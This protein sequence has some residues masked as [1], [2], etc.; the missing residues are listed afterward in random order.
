LLATQLFE[1]H[2]LAPKIKLELSDDEAV[3]EAILAGLGVAIMS[4]YTLGLESEV[5]RL[6]CLDVEGFPLENH[7]HLAY[8]VGKQLSAISRAFMDFA[9]IEAKALVQDSIAPGRQ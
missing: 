6:I 2:G 1:R 9:R 3:K 7:W 8:P 5:S 4:R